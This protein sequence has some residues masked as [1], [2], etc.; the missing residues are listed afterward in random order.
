MAYSFTQP[1]RGA[2]PSVA[3][4]TQGGMGAAEAQELYNELQNRE[5]GGG[6]SKA[7]LQDFDTLINRLESS[8]LRQGAQ[9]GRQVQRQTVTQGLANMMANF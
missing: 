2:I 9:K 3:S 4:L 7:E 5:Y 8:K 1:N 6:M